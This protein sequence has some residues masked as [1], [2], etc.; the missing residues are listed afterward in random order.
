MGLGTF[1][2][3]WYGI[4]GSIGLG[5]LEGHLRMNPSQFCRS[6]LYVFFLFGGARPRWFSAGS[7]G[8][9]RTR[10]NRFFFAD[11]PVE[12]SNDMSGWAV[13]VVRCHHDYRDDGW[14]DH[15]HGIKLT[16]EFNVRVKKNPKCLLATARS[17]TV[18]TGPHET[19]DFVGK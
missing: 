11:F 3:D 15:H 18:E 9:T 14:N 8:V 16:Q 5:V 17:E 12:P 6:S 4:N 2:S 10:T 7:H 1:L 13:G 19:P